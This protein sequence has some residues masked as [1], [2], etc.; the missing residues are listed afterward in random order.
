M[1]GYSAVVGLLTLG[2]TI[3]AQ[4]P[5]APAQDPFLSNWMGALA[6]AI[7]GLSMLDVTLPGTH[8]SMTFDLSTR[9]SDGAND[10]PP[11]IAW[12]LHEFGPVVGVLGAGDFILRL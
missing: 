4:P 10:L 12:V 1:L 8:D 3:N 9:V 7:G 6:P 2:T 5:V 11:A